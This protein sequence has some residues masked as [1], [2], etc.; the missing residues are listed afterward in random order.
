MMAA[1]GELKKG[2]LRKKGTKDNSNIPAV[3]WQRCYAKSVV[4]SDGSKIPGITVFEHCCNV[5]EVAKELYKRLGVCTKS[6]LDAEVAVVSAAV[7]DVGKVSPGYQLKYFQEKVVELAPGLANRQGFEKKHASISAAAVSSFFKKPVYL[8]KIAQAV[9]AHHGT[10]G[11]IIFKD[12]DEQVGGKAWANERRGLMEEL[13]QRYGSLQED[14]N[15]PLNLDVLSGIICVADWIGSTE[16]F[17]PP[18]GLKKDVDLQHLAAYALT[19]CGWEQISFKSGLSFED[20]FGFAP[21]PQQEAFYNNVKGPGIYVLEAGMGTG[22][23]EAALYAAYLLLSNGKADGLYFGLP[24]R[25]TSD[26]IHKRVLPV[27]EQIAR[28]KGDARSYVKLAHGLAWLNDLQHDGGGALSPGKDWFNPLKRSLLMPFSVGTI[29]QALLSVLRVRHFFV[30]TFGLA[31]KVVILDEVHSYD[32]YTGTLLDLLVK[33]LRDVGC[34]VIILSATLTRA[35]RTEL[36]GQGDSGSKNCQSNVD[37]DPYPLVTVDCGG[38]IEEIAPPAPAGIDVTASVKIMEDREV[39]S[40]A[41][42]HAS[43]GQCVVCIENTVNGA[44]SLYNS[45]KGIMLEGSFEVGVLHSKFLPWRRSEIEDYWIDKLGKNGD[46]SSGCV[47]VATQVVE[48]SVNIDAD[49]MITELAPTDMLLQRIGRLWRHRENDDKRSAT[50]PEV[51]I[52]CK[53]D[54]EGIS[55]YDELIESFGKG[56]ARVYSPYVLWRTYNVWCK[57]KKLQVPGDIRRLVEL[58][59]DEQSMLDKTDSLPEFIVEARKSLERRREKLKKLAIASKAESVGLPRIKERE[60]VSTR[61]SDFPSVDALLVK[62]IEPVGDSATMVLADGE[63]VTVQRFRRDRKTTMKLHRNLMSVPAYILQKVKKLP[64]LEK[65]FFDPVA[66]LEIEDDL[67]GELKW[68]GRRIGL[69]Y[70]EERGLQKIEG[71][72]N[73][74]SGSHGE[75]LRKKGYL[76][77]EDWEA[78]L[79]ELDW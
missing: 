64:Y 4:G 48:Q 10:L 70:D 6:Q 20:I 34:T 71:V 7:H 78:N 73:P 57:L 8:S 68:E 79:D 38:G 15:K 36:L 37:S 5:A 45:I 19:S 23:T 14:N 32:M 42:K 58:T 33:K 47:L 61:Y 69:I 2:G 13:A 76:E 75:W 52:T 54:V 39:A 40:L 35:R 17:F 41:V 25:L 62:S 74:A 65:H 60:Q 26:K 18:E 3:P 9:G 16:A 43:D 55:S 1:K 66:V 21:Y 49:Y 11:E 31:G 56:S 22:K 50:R 53:G 27:I 46:R 44:Q 59:Y 29:D 77:N 28:I 24:T 30:R 72:R 12:C 63:E 51:L 67:G